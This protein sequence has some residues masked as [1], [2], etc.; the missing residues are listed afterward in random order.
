MAKSVE[1]DHMPG[2]PPWFLGYQNK[3]NPPDS[4][5][6]YAAS[7][8]GF[9]GSKSIR[10]YATEPYQTQE[11]TQ[12]QHTP[13]FLDCSFR[14]N[15]WVP[16][17]RAAN[18]DSAEGLTSPKVWPENAEYANGVRLKRPPSS[19]RYNRETTVGNDGNREIPPSLS[20]Y[21]DRCVDVDRTLHDFAKMESSNTF[22]SPTMTAQL[23]FETMWNDR[24]NK[25][26]SHQLRATLKTD[27][28]PH[29]S[30]GLTDSTDHI[31][32]S[33]KT[34]MI[35]HSQSSDELRFRL[36]LE[37]SKSFTPYE[38]RWK[39]VADAFNNI[40]TYLTSK[41]ESTMAVAI[42][43]IGDHL[44]EVA[45][46]AGAPTQLKR[47][48]FVRCFERNQY[49]NCLEKQE[50]S[51]LFSTFDPHRKNVIR[52]VDLLACFAVLDCTTQ[53]AIEKLATLW[54][55]HEAFGD[56]NSP[57]DIAL[58]V[59]CSCSYSDTDRG[60][61]EKLFKES[62]RPACYQHS[63]QAVE[64]A[65]PATASKLLLGGAPRPTGFYV[66]SV[67]SPKPRP[68]TAGHPGAF[69]R[70]LSG[71]LASP[72]RTASLRLGEGIAESQHGTG[73]GIPSPARAATAFNV[74]RPGTRQKVAVRSAF[75]ISDD[76]LTKDTFVVITTQ[77]WALVETFDKQLSQRLIDCYGRDARLTPL[78]EDATSVPGS[79]AEKKVDFSWI[80]GMKGK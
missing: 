21:V 77:C 3:I 30:S 69:H 39:T 16:Q 62:F 24:V 79:D 8:Y 71:Q 74:T 45:T 50:A 44:R 55:I 25:S 37:A 9:R 14:I 60:A 67:G 18:F 38:K 27:Y 68:S 49:T 80:L 26:A 23:K 28:P 15:E 75:N 64:V 48:D 57:M 17:I 2:Q 43:Q 11:R 6:I 20:Q 51:I 73:G 5:I 54:E 59:F 65:R 10:Q 41:K 56:D 42:V 31:K 61:V 72:T 63:L 33:G 12:T 53:S 22:L 19:I 4:S 66:E 76:Y 52:Y 58:A 46:S 13:K 32:Y 1:A 29:Q 47:G 7:R 40:K 34:A 70:S 78:D 36:R 35:V